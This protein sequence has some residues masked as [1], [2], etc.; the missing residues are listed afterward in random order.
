VADQ[1][2]DITLSPHFTLRE[3]VVTAHRS[4]DNVPKDALIL[5][6]LRQL[7]MRLLEPVR[8]H[9]GPLRISSGYRCPALN[10]AIGGSNTSAHCFGC[11]ADFMPANPAISSLEVVRWVMAQKDN[12]EFD[13]V[14][15]EHSS[16]ANWVHLALAKPGIKV[17]RKEALTFIAGKYSPFVAA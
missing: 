14:I 6:K 3:L 9:F 10:A 13:Q 12:L 8:L 1:N 15:D 4:I 17:P 7:S 16:T 11:A 2:L 5:D